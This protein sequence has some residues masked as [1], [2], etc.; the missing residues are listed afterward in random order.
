MERNCGELGGPEP[1][2]AKISEAVG[3]SNGEQVGWTSPSIEFTSLEHAALWKGTAAS[4]VDLNPATARY[5]KALGVCDGQ[6]GAGP[7]QT[8]Q[9]MGLWTGTAE[10]WVDSSAFLPAGVYSGSEATGIYTS[11]G[12]TW[13]VG[14]A[15]DLSGNDHAVLWENTVPEPSSALFLISGVVTMAGF[16]LRLR[17]R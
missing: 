6:Q 17:W 8:T 10:S 15:T 12:N 9:S 13:V 11:G 16:A 1:C 7:I 14:Y 4:W 2:R 5:S 3:V